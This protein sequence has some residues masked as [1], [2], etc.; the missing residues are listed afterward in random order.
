MKL[1]EQELKCKIEHDPLDVSKDSKR[2]LLHTRQMLLNVLMKVSPLREV[3][4]ESSER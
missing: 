2:E 3:L 4:E 1:V